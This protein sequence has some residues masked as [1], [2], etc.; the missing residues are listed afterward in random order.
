M[1]LYNVVAGPPAT[2]FPR[3]TDWQRLAVLQTE[4]EHIGRKLV[5][6]GNH[7]HTTPTPDV[8]RYY[9]LEKLIREGIDID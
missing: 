4:R 5:R 6:A 3:A 7:A 1:S 2:S 9:T 8:D